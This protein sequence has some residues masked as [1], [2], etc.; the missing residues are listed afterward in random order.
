[1]QEE[2]ALPIFT[3]VKRTIEISHWGN[4]NVEDYY[5]L[6]NQAAGIQGEFNRVDFQSY[7]PRSAPYALKRM[8]TNLP[9]YITGL[10]YFDYIGNISSSNAHRALNRVEFAIEPRFPIFGQWKADW[11]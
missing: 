4:I 3:E 6:F 9:P 5:N 8:E 7:N 2:A 11:S 10:Y 1:M